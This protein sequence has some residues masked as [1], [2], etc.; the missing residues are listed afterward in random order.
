MLMPFAEV[1]FLQ[2][3]TFYF[4]YFS[5]SGDKVEFSLLSG[6]TGVEDCIPESLNLPCK[7]SKNNKK[8]RKMSECSV[9]SSDVAPKFVFY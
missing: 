1:L 6:D 7:F 2:K 3:K 4:Y 5:I 9:M 8:K